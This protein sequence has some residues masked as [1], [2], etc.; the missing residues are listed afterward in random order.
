[1]VVN[2]K[3]IEK[4]IKLLAY[5]DNRHNKRKYSSNSNF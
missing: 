4:S 3:K 5:W 1:M 2:Y